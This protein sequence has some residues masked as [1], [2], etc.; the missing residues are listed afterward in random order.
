MAAA[1]GSGPAKNS[2]TFT[3]D[4]SVS[5]I[6]SPA[7]GILNAM[8]GWLPDL[9]ML[10]MSYV[11]TPIYSKLQHHK[12]IIATP[13][14]LPEGH[15]SIIPLGQAG[16]EVFFAS[17]KG[18]Q[19]CF[20][21]ID[22]AERC[23]IKALSVVPM[24]AA[25]P[26][27]AHHPYPG[28]NGTL[29]ARQGDAI[30]SL[31]HS[32]ANAADCRLSVW[33][34]HNDELHWEEF[35]EMDDIPARLPTFFEFDSQNNCMVM[36]SHEGTVAT[37]T[38]TD[39]ED[40]RGVV[41]QSQF[42]NT[43]M[44]GLSTAMIAPKSHP[45]EA[46]QFFLAG[47]RGVQL[48]STDP[49]LSAVPIEWL[50]NFSFTSPLAST[51]LA[52]RFVFREIPNQFASY[53]TALHCLDCHAGEKSKPGGMTSQALTLQSFHGT[54]NGELFVLGSLPGSESGLAARA[55]AAATAGAEAGQ[56][57]ELRS[58][59]NRLSLTA[60]LRPSEPIHRMYVY[61]TT[62]L[63]VTGSNQ[64]SYV[65]FFPPPPKETAAAGAAAA[66]APS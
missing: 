3:P 2:L 51:R 52:D 50:K 28:A 58:D 14:S 66:A 63:A 18:N 49:I 43:K 29:F 6:V 27:P 44:K 9:T 19:R 16:P 53:R 1:A 41:I 36:A 21:I 55:A 4:L 59:D 56:I 31:P 17:M 46:R 42:Y 15:N 57:V 24:S 64:F 20:N 11:Q 33:R 38:V 12:P 45:E 65:E 13:I 22:V 37:L 7:P 48:L 23:S 25:H 32:A 30:I 54:V 8:R 60:L 39:P 62:I 35:R 26:I 61:D 40:G 10:I 47:Q 5:T 34:V